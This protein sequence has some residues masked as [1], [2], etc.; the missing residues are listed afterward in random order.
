MT[1]FCLCVASLTSSAS[2]ALIAYI[3]RL[4]LALGSKFHRSLHCICECSET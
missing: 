3:L 1:A 4:L 2:V